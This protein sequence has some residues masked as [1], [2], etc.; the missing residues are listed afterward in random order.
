MKKSLLIIGLIIIVATVS[1]GV[2]TYSKY[3]NPQTCQQAVINEV[4]LMRTAWNTNLQSLMEQEKASSEKVD[5]AFEG[6]RTY[7]C[8]LDYLCKMVS[9]SGNGNE[10]ELSKYAIDTIPG[11]LPPKNIIIPTTK[12]KFI[13]QCRV[14]KANAGTNTLEETQANYKMCKDMVALEFYADPEEKKGKITDSSQALEE[15]KDRSSAY[16]GLERALKGDS[17]SQKSRVLK[18]KLNSILS[19]MHGMETNMVTLNNYMTKFDSLLPCL[20]GKCD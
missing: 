17:A 2:N 1:L 15:F 10:T 5:E 6:M 12:L 3:T 19:R 14:S 16:I 20:I 13:P 18:N 4:D 11:C 8:W 9:Y 7:R